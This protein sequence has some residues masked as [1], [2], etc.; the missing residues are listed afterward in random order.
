MEF[1]FRVQGLGFWNCVGLT[2]HLR[3]SRWIEISSLK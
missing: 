2:V 1:G 3:A